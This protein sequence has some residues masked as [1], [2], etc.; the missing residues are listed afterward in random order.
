MVAAVNRWWALSV[1]FVPFAVSAFLHAATD[2]VM[3]I[4]A[5]LERRAKLAGT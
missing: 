1:A 2:Y 4:T 3:T 5:E